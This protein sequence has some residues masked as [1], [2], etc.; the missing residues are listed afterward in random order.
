MS[1]VEIR[2]W[3]VDAFVVCKHLSLKNKGDKAEINT[4]IIFTKKIIA[5]R[6]CVD[7]EFDI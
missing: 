5:G 7:L 3:G 4:K 1:A 6:G 2:I